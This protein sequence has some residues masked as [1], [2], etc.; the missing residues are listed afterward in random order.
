LFGALLLWGGFQGALDVAMNTQG[1]AVERRLRHPIMSGLHGAWSIGG[2]VGAG[3][4][5]LGVSVGLTLSEQLA[6]EAVVIVAVIG[7]LSLRMLPDRHPPGRRSGIRRSM[8]SAPV[9]A[10]GFVAFAAMLA[11]GAAAD[12]SALYLREVTGASVTYAGLGY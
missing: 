5:T 12:W 11:E 7:T 1:V 8:L 2:A 4:G 10:L 6:L 9:L 3:L